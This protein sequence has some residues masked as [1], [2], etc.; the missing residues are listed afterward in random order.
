MTA[1][2]RVHQVQ[3]G[4]TTHPTKGEIGMLVSD[5]ATRWCVCEYRLGVELGTNEVM[6]PVQSCADERHKRVTEMALRRLQEMPGQDE[7]IGHLYERTWEELWDA[8]YAPRR[9]D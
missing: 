9:A 2:Q 6:F 1:W 8:Q 4:T 3:V 7:E 5:T